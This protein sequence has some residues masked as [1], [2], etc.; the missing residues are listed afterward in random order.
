MVLCH[1]Q[2]FRVSFGV[3][4]VSLL[5]VSQLSATENFK[6]TQIEPP[7]KHSRFIV[8]GEAYGQ[9]IWY[10][11]RL[12]YRFHERGMVNAGYSYI[13]IPPVDAGG[14][15]VAFSIVPVSVSALWP[16]PFTTWPLHAELL[17]GGNIVIGGNRT[18]R[19]G[20][21]ATVTGQPFTPTVGFAL[22][23]VPRETGIVVRAACY[24]FQGI[25]SVG[26]ESRRLPW[27]G[28]SLGYAF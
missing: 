15:T 25:D 18:E 14:N 20:V 24:I 13:E 12:S 19:T 23:W 9:G 10:S 26:V 7:A 6:N 21:R 8:G 27:L 28:G 1:T 17:F 4:F 5:M 16:L 11:A 2:L 22:A 3:W